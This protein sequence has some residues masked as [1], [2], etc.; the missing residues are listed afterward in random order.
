MPTKQELE[1]QIKKLQKDNEDLNRR[2]ND[3][4]YVPSN[5][6]T[7]K[8]ILEFIDDLPVKVVKK[9]NQKEIEKLKEENKN[10]KKRALPFGWTV[11][12]VQAIKEENEKLKDCSYDEYCAI[13]CEN[14]L[15][16]EWV[17]MQSELHQL[18]CMLK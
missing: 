17:D 15:I 10:L 8:A 9:I 2:L 6:Y 11:E 16:K 4:N 14:K 12:T 5:K 13:V 1:W 7:E 3:V 18:A